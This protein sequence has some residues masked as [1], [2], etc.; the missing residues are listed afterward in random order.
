MTDT[1]PSSSAATPPGGARLPRLFPEAEDG[2]LAGHQARHGPLPV[3]GVALIAEVERAGLRGRGGAG[4]PTATKL[5]AVAGRRRR[6]VVVANGT[7]GEPASN[8]DKT[9]LSAAPHLVLDG[10]T[11]AAESVGARL[12]IVAI[13]RNRPATAAAVADA[14]RAR[15]EAGIE[16]VEVRLEEAPDRYV[17]GEESALVHWLNGGEAKPL[18]VPPRPFEKGVGGRPTLVDNVETLAHIA[19]IGR[20]GAPWFRALGTAEDPG[21]TLL[22]VSG[23]VV[24]PGVYEVAGGSSLA[25]VIEGAGAVV[26]EVPAVLIGGYFGTWVPGSAMGELTLGADSLR[27]AGS[28]LGCGVV[29]ALPGEACG[30]QESARVARWLAG[31]NAGQCGPCVNGLD[32]LA[33]VMEALVVGGS[34]GGSGGWG[35]GTAAE[36]VHRLTAE[37]V[38]RGACKHPDGAVRFVQSSLRVFAG[39]V[40]RHAEHGPCGAPVGYLPTPTP[41]A[42]R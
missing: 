5:K 35:P 30:L 23:A 34:A 25:A 6:S 20:Y 11:L 8:K 33:G 14:I 1:A 38:G 31:E 42:W 24:R 3:R 15:R 28:S 27:R 4:F 9:L 22:T 17:A 19:L 41:G 2:S 32:A 10:A 13:E 29:L 12:I 16:R 37:I 40:A 26:A 21:T 39:E 36:R 18:F 7:E